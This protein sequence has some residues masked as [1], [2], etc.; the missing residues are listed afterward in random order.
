MFSSGSLVPVPKDQQQQHVEKEDE[1]CRAIC[2][3]FDSDSE[4][5][6]DSCSKQAA[7]KRRC[8]QASGLLLAGHEGSESSNQS[9]GSIIRDGLGFKS[10]NSLR[11]SSQE[12]SVSGSFGGLSSCSTPLGTEA[13]D[14]QRSRKFKVEWTQELHERFVNAVETLGADKAVPSKILEHM[15]PI[16]VG[17]T[18]QNV[19]SHL[20]KYRTR[21]RTQN[22]FCKAAAYC[23]PAAYQCWSPFSPPCAMI[24]GQPHMMAGMPMCGMPAMAWPA[25]TPMIPNPTPHPPLS[26]TINAAI[27]DILTRPKGGKPPLGLKL[28]TKQVLEAADKKGL[29]LHTK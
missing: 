26:A 2:T 8:S 17:L 27:A 6:E 5:E 21:K 19:A 7:K 14:E 10:A 3:V 9:E 4:S 28:D 25:A 11:H 12:G 13:G 23:P 15:G 24:G 1:L 18:R 16:A 29:Q 22:D 20:Q